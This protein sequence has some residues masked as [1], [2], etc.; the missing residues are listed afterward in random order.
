MYLATN[1]ASAAVDFAK[2]NVEDGVVNSP[3]SR[4]AARLPVCLPSSL[5]GYGSTPTRQRSCS[6]IKGTLRTPQRQLYCKAALCSTDKVNGVSVGPP[7][8]SRTLHSHVSRRRSHAEMGGRLVRTQSLSWQPSPLLSSGNLVSVGRNAHAIKHQ[9]YLEP[10]LFLLS[11]RSREQEQVST[12]TSWPMPYSHRDEIM[13]G[14]AK[15]KAREM[16]SIELKP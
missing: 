5:Q 4:D 1:D 8:K 15:L 16:G 14:M 7:S 10:S 6:P 9:S 13:R 11:R 12:G 3:P 2:D